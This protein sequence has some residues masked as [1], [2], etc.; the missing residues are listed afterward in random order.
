MITSLKNRMGTQALG[1]QPCWTSRAIT[2]TQRRSD[3]RIYQIDGEAVLFDPKTHT[4]LQLNL[5]AL[6]IF[7][8]CDGKTTMRQVAES[9]AYSYN[10]TFDN[11]HNQVE[12]VVSL[13]ASSK[14]LDV[15]DGV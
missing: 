11:A 8:R 12:Q 6:A 15:E 1:K 4:I 10:V 14:L 3:I 5:T 9:L 2:I 7:R 13:F